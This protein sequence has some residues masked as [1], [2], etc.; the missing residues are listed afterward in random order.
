ME[1]VLRKLLDQSVKHLQALEGRGLIEFKVF[2]IDG[3]EFGKMKATKPKKKAKKRPSP[4]PHGELTNY[5]TPFMTDVK[6]DQVVT[7]P[8]S[9]YDPERIRS[10]ACSWASSTWGKNTYSSTVPKGSNNV[11]IYRFPA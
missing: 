4:Y 8:V 10:I 7:I 5:V 11:E 3:E 2:T 6:P 1:Q 9:K